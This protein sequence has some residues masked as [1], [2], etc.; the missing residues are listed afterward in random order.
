MKAKRV[1]LAVMVMLLM[2]D[3]VQGA[4]VR[5]GFSPSSLDRND[6]GSTGVVPIGFD[7]NFFGNTYSNLYVNNNGNVTF[8]GAMW[9]Y[10]PPF[11][12]VCCDCALLAPL[13]DWLEAV[14]F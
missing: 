11:F 3:S 7:V 10:T 2:F 6:D 5:P 9:D 14:L 8:S 1:F 4:A 13:S 12:V